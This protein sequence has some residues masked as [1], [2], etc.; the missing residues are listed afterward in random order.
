MDRTTRVLSEA[1]HILDTGCTLRQ[2]AAVYGVGK[3]TVHT[4]VTVRLRML[5]TGLCEQVSQVL[6][7][8]LAD[9]HLRGGESTKNKYRALQSKRE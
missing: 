9:R 3:S 6:S 4:D 8:N 5:D 2:C 1:R 7:I